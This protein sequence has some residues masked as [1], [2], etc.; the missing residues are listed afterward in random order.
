MVDDSFVDMELRE[1]FKETPKSF[2]AADTRPLSSVSTSAGCTPSPE[3]RPVSGQRAPTPQSPGF[4]KN[5][6]DDDD[7]YAQNKAPRHKVFVGGVPQDLDQDDLKKFFSEIAPVKK[8]WMQKHKGTVPN[9]MQKHRGFGFVIFHEASSVDRLLGNQPSRFL[10]LKD[11]RRIEVKR[12]VSSTDMRSGESDYGNSAQ[13]PRQP[14]AQAQGQSGWNGNSH[15]QNGLGQGMGPPDQ[16]QPGRM[17]PVPNAAGR[18]T[19]VA[20]I[21]TPPRPSPLAQGRMTP[22]QPQ[23]P[24]AG[25]Q[26]PTPPPFMAHAHLQDAQCMVPAMMPQQQTPAPNSASTGVLPTAGNL[27]PVYANGMQMRPGVA[28]NCQ[29][30]MAGTSPAGQVSGSNQAPNGAPPCWPMPMGH[31][32]WNTPVAFNVP[33]GMGPVANE[34]GTYA[35]APNVQ[36][37]PPQGGSSSVPYPVAPGYMYAMAPAAQQQQQ[38]NAAQVQQQQMAQVQQ[39]QHQQMAHAQQQQLAQQQQMAQM[40]QVMQQQHMAQPQ[41]HPQQTYR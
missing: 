40:Q 6:K 20:N 37:G 26:A 34:S 36:G 32:Q 31:P 22:N 28:N 12:A 18:M 30:Q 24:W 4:D 14:G 27:V 17:T 33:Y 38:Q 39:Q 41:Q 7:K 8:A 10:S 23:S 19:P 13:Q 3:S 25:N 9:T 1:L 29:P 21:G 2:T 5:L 11:G 16:S 35:V 15:L